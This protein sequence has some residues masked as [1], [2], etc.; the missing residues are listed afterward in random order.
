MT[1]APSSG[2]GQLPDPQSTFPKA[3]SSISNPFI[4]GQTWRI[5]HWTPSA[6]SARGLRLLS[7]LHTTPFTPEPL[8]PIPGPGALSYPLAGP[9]NSV[10]LLL[11]PIPDACSPCL[12]INVFQVKLYQSKQSQT[13]PAIAASTS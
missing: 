3:P 9:G 2:A 13:G 4:S 11:M 12:G 10:I 6:L 8:I 1:A 7:R 5:P